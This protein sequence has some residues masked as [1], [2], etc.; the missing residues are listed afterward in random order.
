MRAYTD[1]GSRGP[2]PTPP[3][4]QPTYIEVTGTQRLPVPARCLEHSTKKVK[5]M[6]T[7]IALAVAAVSLAALTGCS[8]P[9]TNAQIGTG[10][11]AV[12]GGVV[13]SAIGG[14]AATVGGAAAGALI[15]NQLG[16]DKDRRY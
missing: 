7:K 12:V 9:P 14:T 5:T 10:A 1:D 2:S 11:G 16:K 8:S 13:G 6:Y 3:S 4:K 15:G